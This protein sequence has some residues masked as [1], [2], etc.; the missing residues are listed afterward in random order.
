MMKRNWKRE[1]R[2]SGQE[3]MF[4]VQRDWQDPLLTKREN[5]DRNLIL[6]FVIC[7]AFCLSLFLSVYCQSEIALT[8]C[9]VTPYGCLSVCLHTFLSKVSH[10]LAQKFH[11]NDVDS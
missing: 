1:D 4:R 8:R 10:M 5:K 3:H 11:L 7:Y 9:I 2:R 6:L